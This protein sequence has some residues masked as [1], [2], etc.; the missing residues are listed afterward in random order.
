MIKT[1]I[2]GG[3]GYTAGELIRILLGHPKVEIVWALSSSHT[4]QPIHMVHSDLLGETDLVFSKEA[5]YNAVDVIFLCMG[6]GRSAEL[7]KNNEIP[8]K[9]KIIDLSEDFRLHSANNDFIY[10]LPEMNREKIKKASKIANPGCF[11]TS[12]EL[13]LLPLAK[14]NLLKE[15]HVHAITG[16]TGAGQAPTPTTHFSWRDSNISI[17][18]AFQHRHLKE[19]VQTINDLMPSFKDAVNFIPMRGDFTRGILTS[20]YLECDLQ[21]NEIFK[22]YD[23]FYFDAP[24]TIRSEQTI[25]LK[26]VVNTNKCLL[27]TAKYGNKLHITSIVDNLTKGASGQAVQNMNLMFGINEKEGLYFKPSAF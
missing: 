23:D 1:G 10:G 3:A 21:E 11:A 20:V 17:Y 12:I 5:D 27:H 19:V 2:I 13:A 25:N 26:Q 18:K 7:L 14:N 16:S 15:I 24:F 22:L 8:E 9:V 4:N 6:H